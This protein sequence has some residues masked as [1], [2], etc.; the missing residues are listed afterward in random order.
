LGGRGR[1]VSEFEV[2]DQPGLQSEFQD[3]QGY[4]E[5]PCLEKPKNQKEKEK[6][7]KTKTKQDWWSLFSIFFLFVCFVFSDMTWYQMHAGNTQL[8]KALIGALRS[9][10]DAKEH[11][12]SSSERPG[13]F[14]A[15]VVT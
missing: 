14:M 6:I 5:K 9:S 3:S 1:Q 4:T 2:R 11:V 7:N 13:V 12:E 15:G 10:H 8:L